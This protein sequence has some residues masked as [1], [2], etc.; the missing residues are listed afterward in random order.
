MLRVLLRNACHRSSSPTWVTRATGA[1]LGRTGSPRRGPQPKTPRAV[2]QLG[3]AIKPLKEERVNVTRLASR[4]D[5]VQPLLKQVCHLLDCCVAQMLML[6]RTLRLQ[7]QAVLLEAPSED[8][9]RSS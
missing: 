1:M 6:S 4:L 7:V 2:V 5:G 9:V 8:K 3:P